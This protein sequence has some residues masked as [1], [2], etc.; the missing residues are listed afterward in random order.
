MS[1]VGRRFRAYVATIAMLGLVTACGQSPALPDPT[2]GQAAIRAILQAEPDILLQR[3]A[4]ESADGDGRKA[5]QL[6]K[7]FKARGGVADSLCFSATLGR[8]LESMGP[9]G[10]VWD[11]LSAFWR[12]PS[13]WR[14]LDGQSL[15]RG[16][17]RKFDRLE[18]RATATPPKFAPFQ[19][20]RKW[21][22][23]GA[24]L[25]TAYDDQ[26]CPFQ[27]RYSLPGFV[28]DY[29]VVDVGSAFGI[30]ASGELRVYRWTG[31]GW[32]LVARRESWIA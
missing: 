21:L 13:D 16:E 12:E 1:V 30:L 9:R 22:P 4:W 7:D 28:D 27:T 29:L 24:R 14:A 25:A 31:K 11:W 17:R 3:L 6:V 18:E 23:A 20:D 2:Q 32:L 8:Q 19:I 15:E 5:E 26:K 10:G